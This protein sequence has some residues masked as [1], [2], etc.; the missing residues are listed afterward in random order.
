VSQYRVH[1]RK[2]AAELL[3][4]N[5]RQVGGSFFLASSSAHHPGP[6]RIIDLLNGETGFFPFE[7]EDQ[8]GADTTL[9]NRTQVAAVKILDKVDEDSAEIY[10]FGT[11]RRVGMMLTTGLRV[12]GTIRVYLPVGRDRLSDYV[13][14][15]E[16]F[17]YIETFEGILI[18]NFAHVVEI[19]E[20]A[21]AQ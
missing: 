10:E 21:S 6:E 4:A 5:G 14:T 7:C 15:G 19:R 2:A 20:A 9:Y 3:L 8:W 12:E 18:I 11:E 17:R 13:R 1:K 16:C